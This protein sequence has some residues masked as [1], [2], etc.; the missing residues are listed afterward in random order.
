MKHHHFTIFTGFTPS[1]RLAALTSA[2]ALAGLTSVNHAHAAPLPPQH[3]PVPLEECG[4][5]ACPVGYTCE[6]QLQEVCYSCPPAPSGDAPAEGCFAGCET[7]SFE[8]CKPAPCE[9]DADCGDSMKCHTFQ[10]APVPTAA[11][12]P[13]PCP[14]NEPCD[15]PPGPVAYVPETYQQCTPRSELPCE[16]ASECGEGYDCVPETQCTCGGAT[17]TAPTAVPAGAPAVPTSGDALPVPVSTTTAP[18]PTSTPPT[19]TLTGINRCQV[20]EIECETEADC[21]EDWSCVP[22]PQPCWRDSEGNSGCIDTGSRCYP[23][24]VNQPSPG[25]PGT[26]PQ[27]TNPGGATPPI[28]QPSPAPGSTDNTTPAPNNPSSPTPP[29]TYPGPT[30]PP[31]N[32]GNNP[33][34]HQNPLKGCAVTAPGGSSSTTLWAVASAFLGAALLRRRRVS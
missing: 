18:T 4:E 19:C 21:P 33:I 10:S 7:Q 8:I 22:Q 26:T 5:D 9:T 23:F 34:H 27:P 16:E 15:F 11:P 30:S 28:A 6:L 13:V 20:Q 31:A 25:F 14:L 12:V 32:E 29:A 2:A 24:A 1:F 3:D 17:P